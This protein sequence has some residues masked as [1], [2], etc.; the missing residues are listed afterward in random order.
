MNPQEEFC[1]NEKCPDRGKVNHGNVVCHSQQDQ[2]C[3]C[4]T[5]DKTFSVTRGTAVYGIKKEH[6]LFWMVVTLLA[7]GCPVQ[8]V[9]AAFGLDA[10][11]VR[12][13]Y[14]KSGQHC[15]QVHEH[16]MGQTDLDLEQVQADELKV[17]T[18]GGWLWMAL[19]IM[20]SSRLWL[21]GA[22]S[23]Q[24]DKH[25]IGSVKICV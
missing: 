3:K 7:F 10:R 14:L 16:M 15:Q 19:A 25:L 20:V 4:T 22:V 5:C 11:T 24:R 6:D 8:A 2:R 13:W 17:K 23:E 21:G 18:Q 1:P 9:V 12:S